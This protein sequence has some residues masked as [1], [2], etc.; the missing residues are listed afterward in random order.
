MVV[1]V[2]FP[3]KLYIHNCYPGVI[4]I[5]KTKYQIKNAQ[6]RRFSEKANCVYETYKNT[7][8]TH[9]RHIYAI[10]YDTA[11]ATMCA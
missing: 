11:K 2:E 1:N 6:N 4:G 9:G 7:G 10:A 5:L 3:P 8:M